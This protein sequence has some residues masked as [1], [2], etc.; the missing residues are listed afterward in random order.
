LNTPGNGFEVSETFSEDGTNTNET[1]ITTATSIPGVQT[2]TSVSH[3][4]SGRVEISS[5]VATGLKNT[6]WCM[7]S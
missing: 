6:L 7:G 1:K 3:S 4:S 2:E 5:G